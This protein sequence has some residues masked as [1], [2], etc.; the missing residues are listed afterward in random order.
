L[1]IRAAATKNAEGKASRTVRNLSWFEVREMRELIGKRKVK[2][3]RVT[4]KLGFG[5]K[6]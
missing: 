1:F 4:L 5:L 6:G 2:E 3:L